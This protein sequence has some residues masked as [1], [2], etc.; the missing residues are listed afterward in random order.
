[1]QM[2][3][4]NIIFRNFF[5]KFLIKHLIYKLLI[6]YFAFFKK[7]NVKEPVEK[8]Y[9]A[10]QKINE[11]ELWVCCFFPLRILDFLEKKMTSYFHTEFNITLDKLQTANSIK[12][13]NLTSEIFGK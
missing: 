2:M 3:K 7:K 6:I 1:M 4:C 12:K 13:I 5:N 10:S 11:R 8:Q 9:K